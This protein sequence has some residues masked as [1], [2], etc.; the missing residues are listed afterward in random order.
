MKVKQ[1][2]YASDNLGYLVY[3][4]KDAI[5]I[6]G[7]AVR[8]ILSFIDANNLNLKWVTNT[9]GH[10][11]HTTGT[12]HLAKATN[13]GYLNHKSFREGEELVL[14]TGKIRVYLTP[15]HTM[16]SVTFHIENMIITGDTL[17]NGT[18]GN[19]FSQDLKSFYKS[20]KKL[21]SLPDHT[22]VYGGHDYVRES[23]A[24]AMRIEPDNPAIEEYL[25]RYDA[26]HIWSKLEDERRV[27]P[28]IRFNEKTVIAFLE[29]QGLAVGSEY[30]RWQSIMA[31]D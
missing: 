22:I 20:I 21:L 26:N 1:F 6:D 8:E 30:E 2:R 29:K 19:C 28:Y 16:D 17:F 3:G 15:G 14:E 13:A 25:Q 18:V 31:I 12:R 11:D 4:Q 9:H 7:G 24:V 23:M 5:A 27:N 10:S